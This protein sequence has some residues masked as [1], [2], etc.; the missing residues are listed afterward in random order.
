AERFLWE[1]GDASPWSNAAYLAHGRALLE[2]ADHEPNDASPLRARAA[3]SLAVAAAVDATM[4]ASPYRIGVAER[5]VALEARL[6][7]TSS[8]P[9]LDRALATIESFRRHAAEHH[10]PPTPDRALVD[11]E[12][13]RLRAALGDPERARE[14]VEETAA[15]ARTVRALVEVEKARREQGRAGE[16]K[17][18]QGRGR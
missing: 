3:A 6:L 15:G 10:L 9:A 5:A 4:A 1:V 8:P 2:R 11:L 7:R 13:A 14:I 16:S 17:G 18:E 12:E